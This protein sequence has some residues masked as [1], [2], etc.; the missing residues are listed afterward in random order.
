MTVK[1]RDGE[2]AHSRCRVVR[3][4]VGRVCEGREI[5]VRKPTIRSTGSPI[6]VRGNRMAHFFIAIISLSIILEDPGGMKT[7]I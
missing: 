1:D 2:Y 7:P 5:N 3:C 4:R 6:S